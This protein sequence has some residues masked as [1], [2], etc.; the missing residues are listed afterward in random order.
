[1]I[2]L[3]PATSLRF[4]H[5]T[6]WGLTF[7]AL[8]LCVPQSL[9]GLPK[10]LVIAVDGVPFRDMQALQRGI[11]YK[12]SKNQVVHIQAFHRGYY[13]ASRV[14]STYPSA[15]DVAWTDVFHGRP[16]PGYQRTYYNR[17][18]NR[19]V[20]QNGVT[21]T[22]EYEHEMTWQEDSG[23]HRTMGYVRPLDAFK[24]ECKEL[25][26]HFLSATNRGDVF[27][28]LMRSTDDA[29]HLAGNI[30]EMMVTL[31]EKVEAIRA[32]YRAREGRELEVVLLSDHGNNHAGAGE[33]VRV[34]AY[35]EHAGYRLSKAI[36]GPA[37]VVLPTAGI[38]TWV[39][40]HNHP[41]ET[42]KLV[43]L[44]S[45][46]EGTDV[47]TGHVLG[48]DEHFLVMNA[49]GERAEV[50]FDSSR[51]YAYQPIIGDPLAYA[52]V[53]RQL[54][55][56]HLLQPDGFATAGAWE[57][58]TLDHRYPLAPERIVRGHTRVTQNPATIIISLDNK[59]VNASFLIKKGSEFVKFGGTHG[60]MDDLNCTGMLVSTIAP[61]HDASTT[62]VAGL[63]DGFQ[64]RRDYRSEEKGAEWIRAGDQATAA[65]SALLVWT[66]R[67]AELPDDAPLEIA[68]KKDQLFASSQH[69]RITAEAASGENATIPF[70][71][72]AVHGERSC[73]RT[74]SL[75]P[76][77][78]LEPQTEYRIT[79]WIPGS[80]GE[81][82]FGMTF[83]TDA[84][85]VPVGY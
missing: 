73:K 48:A 37:D 42:E 61:T 8:L 54:S 26:K 10:R 78:K 15:S 1:M 23:F 71:P 84:Q 76:N 38:E 80:G 36:D 41:L 65:R 34:G 72:A 85:G 56:Q 62:R 47:V 7:L 16:L 79:G 53:L 57:A 49:R 32:E 24:R 68:V 13:P 30:L 31:D 21:T 3:V 9:A 20:V 45:H 66:P 44:L 25:A 64:G 55:E 4:H 63:F 46:L 52:G 11:T 77:L 69:F 59:F 82:V 5:L 12:N 29:Q 6:R 81:R 60:G 19:K 43:E 50:R 67:F 33:R 18:A 51:G 70:A 17:A 40:L 35:L 14:I 27:Y 39:E 75:P 74:F 22:M 58:A 28:V 83:C 2:P